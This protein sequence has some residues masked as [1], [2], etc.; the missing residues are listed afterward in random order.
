MGIWRRL[1]NALTRREWPTSRLLYVAPDQPSGIWI[2][3][4]S[5]L[6]VS[7]VWACVMAITDGLAPSDWKV[8]GVDG[9][10]RE[11]LPDHS[12]AYVLNVRPNPEMTAIAMREALSMQ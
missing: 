6:D 10:T 4:E 5:A 2:T 9:E 11:E 7:V 3:P 12:L 1:R 8:F